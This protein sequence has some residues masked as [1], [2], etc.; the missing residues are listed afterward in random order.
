MARKTFYVFPHYRGNVKTNLWEI[1]LNEG[2]Q[3]FPIGG[4]YP[5]KLSAVRNVQ[6]YI[7]IHGLKPT[8]YG[9][10]ISKE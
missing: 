9:T 1:S 5:N 4:V 6:D 2:E 10:V 3:F 7:T 8:E